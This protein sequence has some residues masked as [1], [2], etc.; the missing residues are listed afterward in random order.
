M[1][2]D[3]TPLKVSILEQQEHLH[4]AKDGMFHR[5]LEDDRQNENGGKTS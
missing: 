5:D 3:I 4:D 2:C 1:E